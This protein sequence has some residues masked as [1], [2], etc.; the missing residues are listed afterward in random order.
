MQ[1]LEIEL[2]FG[3][4]AKD[5]ARLPALPPIADA[6]ESERKLQ[7]TTY[8]DTPAFDLEKAGL[9]C[10]IRRIGD[11]RVQTIKAET[12]SGIG[13]HEWERPLAQDGLELDALPK[14]RVVAPLK[15]A[16]AADALAPVFVTEVERRS[17]IV[18]QGASLVEVSLDVGHMAAAERTREICEVELELKQGRIEDL[19]TLAR[20][21]SGDVALRLDLNPKSRHGLR[22]ARGED[23]IETD[24]ALPRLRPDMGLAEG[25]RAI[26]YACLRHFMIN[27]PILRANADA[28]ALHQTR[29]AVRRLRAVLRIFG[30]HVK[31]DEL[32]DLRDGFKWLS[33]VL[34]VARDLDVMSSHFASHKKTAHLAGHLADKREK[35]YGRV[36]EA[37]ESRRYRDLLIDFCAWLEAGPWTTR[38]PRKRSR[39][40]FE[41]VCLLEFSRRDRKLLDD[42]RDLAHLDPEERHAVR[43]RAKSLL[44]A[45]ALTESLLPRRQRKAQSVYVKALKRMQSVLGKLN[46]AHVARENLRET[47]GGATR[48]A[49][50]QALDEAAR[51]AVARHAGKEGRLLE[52]ALKARETFAAAPRV[53]AL[54]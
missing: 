29:T 8:F 32:G 20:Q 16:A 47:L 40:T 30:R 49:A 5:A 43:I 34:G 18:P 21:L 53:W 26:C 9:I 22:L 13:R 7:Q 12:A 50:S 48:D 46:D 15:K 14:S 39:G 54:D 2:K 51:H 11:V 31:D 52:Q 10:R 41:D 36:F 28:E 27:E 3:L 33:R 1:D 24:P 44:Y 17:W 45:C 38:K 25:F 42:S 19:F 35:V 23:A 37:L 6:L 4:S